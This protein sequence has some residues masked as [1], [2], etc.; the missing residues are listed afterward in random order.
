MIDESLAVN[1]AAGVV[2]NEATTRQS[3]GLVLADMG[4]LDDAL[5]DLRSADAMHSELGDRANLLETRSGILDVLIAADR[6]VDAEAFARDLAAEI[7]SAGR[8]CEDGTT[9]QLPSALRERAHGAL[10]EAFERLGDDAAS[11]RHAAAAVAALEETLN[12]L[13]TTDAAVRRAAVPLHRR[14]SR[15]AER[16]RRIVTVDLVEIAAGPA[17]PGRARRVTVHWTIERI[18]DLLVDDPAE[19][20]RVVI[21]RLIAEAAAAGGVPTDAELATACGVSR[22]TVL[23]DREIIRSTDDVG[24]PANGPG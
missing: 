9:E 11:A 10:A 6:L 24:R 1:A 8:A 7:T 15:L 21:R 13:E 3:R 4:Q 19:R 12:A 18:D 2:R 5:T 23:R 16:G 14:T 20:R 22:R 17:R